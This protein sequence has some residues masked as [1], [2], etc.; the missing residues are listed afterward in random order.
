MYFGCKDTSFIVYEQQNYFFIIFIV[1]EQQKYRI[2][3][4]FCFCSTLPIPK[5]SLPLPIQFF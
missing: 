5:I 1:Y 3:S 4:I 2:Y